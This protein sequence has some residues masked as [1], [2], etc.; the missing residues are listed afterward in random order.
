MY[1]WEMNCLR[2]PLKEC[3][4]N[5]LE[6]PIIFKVNSGNHGAYQVGHKWNGCCFDIGFIVQACWNYIWILQKGVKNVKDMQ[7]FSMCQ[8][9]NC[10]LLLSQSFWGWALHVIGDIRPTSSKQQKF[11]LVGINYFTKWIEAIPLASVYQEIM[12]EFILKHIIYRFGIRETIT[13]YHRSVFTGWKMQEFVFE[14]GFKLVMSTLYYAQANGQVKA[15]NK[16]IIILIKKHISKK[17][18]NRHKTLDQI[19]WACRTSPKEATNSM[20]FKLT[21]GHNTVLLVDIGL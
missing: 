16:L 18:R 15:T 20:P 1:A 4:L 14:I 13:T 10:M 5:S 11:I 12:I 3:Y 17:P 8:K 2:R 19:L 9:V 7:P 6:K 21:I